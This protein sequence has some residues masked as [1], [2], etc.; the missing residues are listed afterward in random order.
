MQIPIVSYR[1]QAKHQESKHLVSH[2]AQ[3]TTWT[4]ERMGVFWEG[5]WESPKKSVM[6]MDDSEHVFSFWDVTSRELM[7]I[8]TINNRH[9]RV[10]K[11]WHVAQGFQVWCWGGIQVTNMGI[12]AEKSDGP[13]V[14]YTFFVFF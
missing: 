8:P 13:F 3:N 14:F 4:D 11:P 7:C 9:F 5:F 10:W 12:L 1:A 2:N 6:P